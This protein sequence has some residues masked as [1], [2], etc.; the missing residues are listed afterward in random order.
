M[1]KALRFVGYA[2]TFVALGSLNAFAQSQAASQTPSASPAPEAQTTPKKTSP[3]VLAP[4][5]SSNPKLGTA[6]GGLFAYATKFDE[7]SRVSITGFTFQYTTTESIIAAGFARLSLKADHHRIVGLGAFGYIKNDYEDYLGTGQP[8]KTND[9]LKAFAGRYLYRIKGDWFIG[10]QANA[11]NYQ[12]LGETA[13]DDAILES[14]GV[15]GFKSVAIGA[16]GLHD[17]R[18]NEDMPTT[19]WYL[20]ANNLAYGDWFE[21]AS[22]F[23]AYRI[24]FRAFWTHGGKHVLALRQYN[25][26]T[27][28]APLNGQ[29]TVVLRGYKMGQY[30]APYMSS[31]ELEER[32]S[33]HPRWGATL[34]AGAATLYGTS[35]TT[36]QNRDVY[37]TWGG[38][39]HFVLKP[40]KRMLVNLEYAAGVEDNKGAYLKFGYAW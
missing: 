10:A 26:L 37:P 9:D 8:L 7:K 33:F 21:G 2:L 39:I 38:G 11:A 23:E 20:N 24:D 34:F 4:I 22:S 35:P 30:L 36:A 3:W 12:V 25:W 29:A 40:D 19:G 31:I 17:S 27:H 13:Q 15:Q 18:D 6:F 1:V 28:D 32:F 14:L 5:A 16:A